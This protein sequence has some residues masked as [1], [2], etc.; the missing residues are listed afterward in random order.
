M[1]PNMAEALLKVIVQQFRSD[2]TRS[3]ELLAKAEAKGDADNE[4]RHRWTIHLS[5]QWLIKLVESGLVMEA[6]QPLAIEAETLL[7]KLGLNFTAHELCRTL[8]WQKHAANAK[9][10]KGLIHAEHSLRI[11]VNKARIQIA[12]AAMKGV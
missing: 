3:S 5:E 1:T 12:E 4:K 9:D 10:W 6:D 7:P 8:T 2:I 11:W